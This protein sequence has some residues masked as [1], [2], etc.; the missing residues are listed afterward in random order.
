[1]GFEWN[2]EMSSVDV[3][4]GSWRLY[5]HADYKGD[6]MLVCSGSKY[7]ALDTNDAYS[8]VKLVSD[9]ECG[10]KS[11]IQTHLSKLFMTFI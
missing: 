10:G 3:I 8:S 9:D 5:T 6:S 11:S 4:S 1:M 7:S 2:D